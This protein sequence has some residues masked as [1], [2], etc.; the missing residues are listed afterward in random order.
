MASKMRFWVQKMPFRAN[1][2]TMHN[3]TELPVV[4]NG[5][6]FRISFDY[7]SQV[8]LGLLHVPV[9]VVLP[10]PAT[11]VARVAMVPVTAA[12]AVPVQVALA[13]RLPPVLHEG[14]H[15]GAL[16]LLPAPPRSRLHC[17]AS[18]RFG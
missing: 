7:Y 2:L 11:M 15:T 1:K 6:F 3:F 17:C 16:C 8:F 9:T 13:A 14:E 18:V 5:I 12:V 4:K 10:V